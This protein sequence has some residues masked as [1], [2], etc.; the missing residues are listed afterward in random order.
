MKTN[1]LYSYAYFAFQL[2]GLKKHSTYIY[3][4]Y[5]FDVV[6]QGVAL[7]YLFSFVSVNN[8]VKTI[9]GS[10]SH[11]VSNSFFLNAE[12]LDLVIYVEK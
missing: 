7:N 1:K 8:G 9:K 2:L 10:S 3:F 11:N 5:P 4:T 12:S 6:A